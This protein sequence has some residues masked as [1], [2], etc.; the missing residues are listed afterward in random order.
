MS[1]NR[2]IADELNKNVERYIQTTAQPYALSSG[3]LYGGKRVRDHPQ[4]GFTAYSQDPATLVPSNS[5]M[6]NSEIYD[7]DN[8]EGSGISG[9]KYSVNKFV[10]DF[11]KIGKLVKPVAKPIIRAL[12]NKA[13]SKIQ[14]AGVCGGSD[15]VV[16][17]YALNVGDY[18]EMD[19]AGISGG[20]YS[21]KKFARD[22]NKIGK[23]VKPVAKPIIKALTDKAVSKIIGAG[24]R[25][26]GR[27]RKTPLLDMQG[28]GISGGDYY[29]DY[30]ESSGAGISGGKYSVNKFVRDF[31]KIG[32]LVK[33]VAKPIFKALTNK[34]VSK[35]EGAGMSGGAELYPPTVA[36]GSGVSGGA[37]SARGELIKKV[38]KEQGLT[39]GKASK[40]IKDNGLCFFNFE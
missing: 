22:F 19:G 21:V 5:L 40:Y 1:Y 26:R 18:G 34:A 20:K 13:V 12:T 8:L 32:K 16:N 29:G 6:F 28:A 33:P 31:N 24:K 39:L 37:R 30:E 38:M 2:L 11:N 4:Q 9:G 10:R 3:H 36:R 14:G 17:D 23:L 7:D 25:P 27:P 35:I 15:G